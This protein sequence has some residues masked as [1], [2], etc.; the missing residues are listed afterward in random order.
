M[1]RSSAWVFKVGPEDDTQ[2]VCL[3]QAWPIC[4]HYNFFINS[5]VQIHIKTPS[6]Y[7][8]PIRAPTPSQR[9]LLSVSI[10]IQK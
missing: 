7:C 6:R 3:V 5:H 9:I 10:S 4:T 1:T 8:Q 2:L